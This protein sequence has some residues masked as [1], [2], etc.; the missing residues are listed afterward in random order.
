MKNAT[1]R[2]T[3]ILPVGWAGVSPAD[4]NIE[5]PVKMPGVPTDKMSVPLKH[6]L[7]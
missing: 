1:P 2:S 6:S 7:T 3:G 4:Y 5:T